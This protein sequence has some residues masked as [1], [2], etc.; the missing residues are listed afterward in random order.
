LFPVLTS[1][2]SNLPLQRIW[3]HGLQRGLPSKRG[4]VNRGPIP[5]RIPERLHAQQ[6]WPSASNPHPFQRRGRSS[7]KEGHPTSMSPTDARSGTAQAPF[8]PKPVH[9]VRRVHQWLGPGR[10]SQHFHLTRQ[11]LKCTG[12]KALSFL[13]SQQTSHAPL[14]GMGSPPTGQQSLPIVSKTVGL[15]YREPKGSHLSASGPDHFLAISP[16]SS[17]LLLPTPVAVTRCGPCI[18]DRAAFNTGPGT[19]R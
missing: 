19:T 1:F 15:L 9:P 8:H 17:A 12:A 4:L 18:P 16:R 2:R 13:K 14:N 11:P 10:A 3:D 5:R 6:V 7:Q